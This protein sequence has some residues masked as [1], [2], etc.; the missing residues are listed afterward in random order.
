M[1]RARRE[2]RFIRVRLGRVIRDIRRK[3]W[4]NEALSGLL[5]QALSKAGII[6]KQQRNRQE[7]RD[8]WHAPEVERIGKVKA[9]KPYEFGCK[10]SVSTHINSA[11]GGH[12][13]LHIGA[14]HGRP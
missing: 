13:V 3:V 2:E 6:Q 1:K 4:D 11:P 5:S 14:L 12:V 9:A 8:S 10:V 7:K